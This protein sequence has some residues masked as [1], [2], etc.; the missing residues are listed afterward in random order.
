MERGLSQGWSE[1]NV[2]FLDVAIVEI[3]SVKGLIASGRAA[4]KL[5]RLMAELVASEV[6][7]ACK[8]LE[9]PRLGSDMWVSG[10]EEEIQ[11]HPVT[12]LTKVDGN[13]L[14]CFADLTR[15]RGPLDVR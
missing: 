7:C 11:S 12:G 8:G 5:R 1:S 6:L 15:D 9:R 14:L 10:C 2:L 4:V 3:L 13:P